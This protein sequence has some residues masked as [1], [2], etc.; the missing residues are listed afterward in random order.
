MLALLGAV[1]TAT[2]VAVW[3]SQTEPEQ[4]TA[5]VVPAKT[6]VPFP[7]PSANPTSIEPVVS[8]T[9]EQAPASRV[10]VVDTRGT[11]PAS[12][13]APS[14]TPSLNSGSKP[15]EPVATTIAPQTP[16]PQAVGPEP[17]GTVEPSIQVASRTTASPDTI[18]V[19]K[20]TATQSNTVPR[21]PPLI[22]A[23]PP[24]Q[25][26]V[27][28]DSLIDPSITVD[29]F[30]TSG[31]KGFGTGLLPGRASVELRHYDQ[32]VHNGESGR[33]KE[34][35]VAV[36]VQ[37]DTQHYGRFNLRAVGTSADSSGIVSSQYDGGHYINLS[38]RDFAV[39]DHWLMNNEV[40]NLR[41]R[42]P[43][44]MSTSGYI[45]LPEPLLEGASAE[46]RSPDMEFRVSSGT[47]GGYQGRTF[48]VFTTDF[49]SGRA[50]GF[51]LSYRLAPEW[52]A[53][54]Q[55][56][57]SRNV[58]S[59]SGQDSFNSTSAAVQFDGQNQ[60][61]AQLSLLNSD[62]G[63]Q[64]VWFDGEKR[65]SRWLHSLSLYR[66]DPNLNWIDRNNAVLSDQQGVAWRTSTRAYRTGLSVG[67]DASEN[68]LEQ[69]PTKTTTR[70]ISLY[71]N[72]SHQLSNKMSLTGYL[73]RGSQN[74]SGMGMDTHDN[75]TTVQGG[76]S[77]AFSNGTSNVLVNISDRSGDS[78]NQFTRTNTSWD[79]YWNPYAGL[80]NLRTGI[81][82]SQ[83][84]HSSND[85]TEATVR[86]G[87]GWSQNRLNLTGT[88]SY[89]RVSSDSL[90]TNTSS[91]FVFA[92]G[93]RLAN[94]WHLGAD[95][96]YSQNF[97]TTSILGESRVTDRQLM[98]SLRY[99]EAWGRAQSPVGRVNGSYGRGSV[100]GILFLDRNNNGVQDPGEP[101]V[102]G[103]TIY[104]DRGFSVETDAKGEFVIDSVATGTHV[105]RVNT[106]NVPL[107][108]EPRDEKPP[109][110]TV[111]TR[112]TTVVE[113]PLVNLRPN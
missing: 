40:G 110:I 61:K 1:L 9:E 43:G 14:T 21:L 27:Y 44:L 37:Q 15:I 90:D 113:I 24:S 104:L 112:K 46:L 39:T 74:T 111:N 6:K 16:A 42:A 106:A 45:R 64:G 17:R 92:L 4:S 81:Q 5:P 49:S 11:V 25:T 38:Q 69:D 80:N 47:L 31:T 28:H 32:N 63:A 99:N 56:W 53:A 77:N 85:F 18:P 34:N 76:V 22:V 82:F 33:T 87:A 2:L 84:T 23:L 89:G 50:S 98:V 26:E 79:H 55:T 54:L 59:L 48:P 88:A 78:G 94:A 62:N 109:E 60:G 29:P 102:A 12:Q 3:F 96:S 107:P 70:N 71:G 20:P 57:Q 10:A 19:A 58:Q 103:V 83:Q 41:A 36:D 51:G 95:L 72:L 91:S 13:I 75:I 35:G 67:A 66:M 108:W 101:G 97:L 73:L 8:A 30:S 68:N 86:G 105:L 100:R 65:F 7:A 52:Q 93:W